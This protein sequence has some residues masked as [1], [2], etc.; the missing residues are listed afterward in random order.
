MCVYQCRI[1]KLNYGMCNNNYHISQL[2]I[3]GKISRET[4]KVLVQQKIVGQN[5]FFKPISMVL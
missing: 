5:S 4:Q 1:K 3:E 2:P